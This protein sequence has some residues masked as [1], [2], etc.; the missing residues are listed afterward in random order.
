[1]E[2]DRL[3]PKTQFIPKQSRMTSN[4]TSTLAQPPRVV[5]LLSACT[6][7][8]A[9]LG[10]A[11][12]LVGRSHGCDAPELVRAL[13][14]VT[15]PYVD[16]SASSEEIDAQVRAQSASGGPVY[17]LE[18]ERIVALKP[19]I[20]ITQR[21]CRICAVTDKDLAA[22]CGQDETSALGPG[23][24]I[25]TVEPLTLDDVFADVVTIAD[26]LGV[27][28]RGANLVAH[29]RASFAVVAAASTAARGE[30]PPPTVA[31]VEWLNPVMGSGYWIAECIEAAGGRMVVG[32]KGG[33]SPTVN[34]AALAEADVILLAPCGFSMERT[35][36]ELERL[37]WA[38]SEEWR[39]L[40]AVRNNRVIVADGNKHFNRSS[41][42][43]LASAE[44]VAEA[45]WSEELCGRWG[46]HG[47]RW[48]RLSELTA[49]V[50]RPPIK[51]IEVAA[52][53]A[54]AEEPPL[55][56]PKSA[57]P[58]DDAPP[59]MVVLAQVAALQAGAAS[60]AFALN[61]EANAGRLGSA[62]AFWKI[63][64]ASSAFSPLLQPQATFDATA[65]PPNP[66]AVRTDNETT[67][68]LSNAEL[69][70]G[71]LLFDLRRGSPQAPWRTER[72]RPCA[73]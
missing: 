14:A 5:S 38:D 68:R 58:P 66:A 60:A 35:A 65:E 62:R 47:E 50:G 67:V 3:A 7:I 43:V 33:H 41:T 49:F 36:A 4:N 73:C 6:E 34:L 17:H 45:F 26:A 61:T 56:P 23:V 57:P 70:G 27:P 24:R 37:G 8:V 30:K 12:C 15:A 53:S 54:H 10:M 31:H 32:E 16:P 42:A 29:L 20:V 18:R 2:H 28:A 71:A 55:P 21:Q 59:E 46:H 22:A 63:V 19:D 48:V 9:R 40:K 72:V 13:P 51:S 11:H 52:S 39:N 69:P 25:V 1:M 64:A 44:I